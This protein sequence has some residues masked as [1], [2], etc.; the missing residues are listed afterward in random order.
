MR[1][2]LPTLV[3]HL[4]LA[5]RGPIVSSMLNNV[6]MHVIPKLVAYASSFGNYPINFMLINLRFIGPVTAAASLRL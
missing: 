2:A 3:T 4:G 5:S 1:T 6:G